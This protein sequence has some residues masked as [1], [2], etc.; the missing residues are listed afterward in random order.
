MFWLLSSTMGGSVCATIGISYWILTS[1]SF[2]RSLT[3]TRAC[4]EAP[5]LG[6]SVLFRVSADWDGSSRLVSLILRSGTW[7][8]SPR[9]SL[10][11]PVATLAA[12]L[13]LLLPFTG[14]LRATGETRTA[15][16]FRCLFPER[17]CRDTL[18][19]RASDRAFIIR[20][21]AAEQDLYSRLFFCNKS[22]ETAI[23]SPN[24]GA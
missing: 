2:A 22:P 8:R 20:A 16:S 23:E 10:S 7:V 18:I 6:V 24:R 17:S 14:A 5:F 4:A 12:Y 11:G 9:P 3:P 13:S 19:W 1:L 21:F 15:A